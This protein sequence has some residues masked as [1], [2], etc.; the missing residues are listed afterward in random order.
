MVT[1]D[2]AH[3]VGTGGAIGAVLRT[4]V[5]RRV[6]VE[7]FPTG[8]FTVNVVGSFALGLVTFLHLGDTTA[9]LLGTGACG[10]FTTFS[11]FSVETVRLWETGERVRAV[12]NAVGNLVGAG[13]ALGLAWGVASLLA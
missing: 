11:S 12:A 9:L 3:V 6:D 10:S 13:V 5:S 4:V 8:T 2:P 7:E 1:L